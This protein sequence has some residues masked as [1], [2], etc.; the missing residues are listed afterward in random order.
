MPPKWGKRTRAAQ[1][2]AQILSDED[3]VDGSDHGNESDFESDF[4]SD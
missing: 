1:A 4:E 3:D 2:R